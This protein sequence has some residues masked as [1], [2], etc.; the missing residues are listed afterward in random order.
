MTN[1]ELVWIQA[2]SETKEILKAHG[3]HYFLDNGTLLGAVREKAFITWDNDID[4]GVVDFSFDNSDI[5]AISKDFYKK[6]YNVT[7][8]NDGINVTDQTGLL[9]LGIKFYKRE[10]GYYVAH[11][12]KVQ[13]IVCLSSISLFLSP[14]FIYKRGYGSYKFLSIVANIINLTRSIVPKSFIS[15]LNKK[16]NVKFVTIKIPEYLLESFTELVFYGN[17][18]SIPRY[19]EEYLAFRYGLS[20]K[21][22]KQ[23]YNFIIED[24]GIERKTE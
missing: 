21:T 17:K 11:L 1:K 12:G 6:G 24:G 22:P 8:V 19:F 2:L 18:Y 10:T 23:N 20:W 9:D 3:C 5:V 13:G 7:S 16:A 4:I 14:F 15:M